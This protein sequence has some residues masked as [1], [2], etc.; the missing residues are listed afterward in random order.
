MLKFH[1]TSLEDSSKMFH[2]PYFLY[3]TIK[4]KYWLVYF[5]GEGENQ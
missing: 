4:D 3:A 5:W 2:L 1:D